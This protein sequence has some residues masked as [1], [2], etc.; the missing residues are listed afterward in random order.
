MDN[1][2]SSHNPYIVD[3]A[4]TDPAMF[5]GHTRVF[6]WIEETLREESVKEPLILY[7]PPGVGKSSILRQ[8]ENGYLGEWPTVIY[9]KMNELPL[10]TLTDFLWK[11]AIHIRE[12]I[13]SAGKNIRVPVVDRSRFK[14]EPDSAFD[15]YLNR[16][17]ARLSGE[18]Q[19]VLA[20]D[21]LDIL[22]GKSQEGY[23]EYTILTYLHDLLQREDK[24]V[25]IFTLS[26][27]IDTLPSYALAPF[28]LSER[29]PVSNFD[30]ETT[31][32]FLRQSALFNTSAVIGE[33]IYHLTG[34]HPGDIQRYCHELYERQ[35]NNRL[36]HISLADV[37]AVTRQSRESGSFQTPV[38]QR[39]AEESVTVVP[40]ETEI[41]TAPVMSNFGWKRRPRRLPG[42]GILIVIFLV[43]FLG[44][45]GLA[46]ASALRRPEPPPAAAV[47]VASSTPVPE[48]SEPATTASKAP[49]AVA[50]VATIRPTETRLQPTETPVT[51]TRTA[52][53]EPSPTK[54]AIPASSTPTQLPAKPEP[55]PPAALAGAAAVIVREKD[56]MPM[57]VV[58][59][60]TFMMG[61]P[62][63][64]EEA[65]F[66]E[67]PA[68]E[69]TLNTFYMDKFEVTVSQ[70]AAFLNTLGRY[71]SACHGFDCAWPRGRIGYTSYLLEVEEEDGTTYE[72]MAGFEDY[73]INH[74]SWYGAD[75][76]C[77]AMGARL[78]TEAEW[79][80]AARG[81]DGRIYPWGDEAPDET[82]AVFFSTA[83]SDLR[84]VDALP[85]GAS[86]FGIFG[87]AGSMWE[88]VSDWYSPTYYSESPVDNPQ[89]PEDGDSKVA[90]GGGWPNND[91]AA[92]IRSVNRNWHEIVYYSADLGFRCVSDLNG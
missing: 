33:Y 46:L 79:E 38:N 53:A 7:G 22:V 80:Y 50:A 90:R 20:F 9:L 67:L 14:A 5:F 16:V 19:L 61:A 64:D 12:S 26:R 82:R 89:G 71:E 92:R 49:T 35:Q 47:V 65:N 86:P 36:L 45:G 76:Y 87:M 69:V 62:E 13:I 6:T 23:P 91:Q 84:P 28:Q 30:L 43:V 72:A 48:T 57:L 17:I 10:G 4:I 24:L 63:S 15:G 3:A 18:G 59:G 66:D 37:V 41:V 55:T 8:L 2:L 85:N 32:A 75:A 60:D 73:P 58:P 54:T 29:H 56:D 68:H 44:G 51:P 77:R 25:Y 11:L 78:P 81:T 1:S 27:E 39:L 74:V 21:D 42:K 40:G 88:W 52:T 70:Y 83:Y 34:G 31:L